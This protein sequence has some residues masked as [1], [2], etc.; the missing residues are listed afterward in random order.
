MHFLACLLTI[1]IIA[2]IKYL[3]LEIVN[4]CNNIKFKNKLFT[5]KLDLN[6]IKMF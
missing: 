4:Y 3:F 1:T 5:W 6:Q 2:A